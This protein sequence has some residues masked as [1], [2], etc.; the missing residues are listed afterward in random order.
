M[1]IKM[2]DGV[3]IVCSEEEEKLIRKYWKLNELYPEF[4]GHLQ[5]DRMSD[6][7]Y[8]MDKCRKL[9]RSI[10]EKEVNEKIIQINKEIENAEDEGRDKSDFIKKRKFYKDL[11][12]YDESILIKMEHIKE[13]AYKFR[14][15]LNNE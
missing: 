11:L 6:P 15:Q 2:I 12:N 5:F 1:L 10:L 3:E 4:S 9:H 8:D 7:K 13:H 14:K